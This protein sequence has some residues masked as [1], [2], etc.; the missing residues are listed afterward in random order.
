MVPDDDKPAPP[1]LDPKV[2]EL[3]ERDQGKSLEQIV[4]E[5]TAAELHRW[6]GLP[7][8][9]KLED[10][11]APPESVSPEEAADIAR[12]AETLA[13][14]SDRMLADLDYRHHHA[15]DVISFKPMID[16]RIDPEMPMFDDAGL[17]RL[18]VNSEVRELQRPSDIDEELKDQ[19][20]QAL[21]RDLHRSEDTFE[22]QFEIREE[23]AAELVLDAVAEVREAMATSWKLP[24]LGDPPGVAL[25]KIFAQV[26][27]DLHV[28]WGDLPRTVE[29]PNRRVTE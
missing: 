22:K 27:A 26:H 24:D 4:D 23:V 3:I 15:W 6:F 11:G 29:M 17:E 19:T 20:P 2:K 1:T 5:K 13:A 9:Q 16:V 10:E 21:L 18:R 25:R 28:P 12:R 7:S 14:V 8:F